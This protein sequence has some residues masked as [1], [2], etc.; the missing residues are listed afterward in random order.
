MSK[1]V[2]GA[3]F[4]GLMILCGCQA[5][6][7]LTD[8]YQVIHQSEDQQSYPEFGRIV[9]LDPEL[10]NHVDLEAK[11]EKLTEGFWWAEGPSWSKPFGESR[12]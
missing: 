9:A 5:K 11:V 7:E 1:M 4:A 10:A 6:P 3:V 12:G 2:T 8:T